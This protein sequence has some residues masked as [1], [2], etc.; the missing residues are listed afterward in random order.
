MHI[1]HL[2]V[3]SKWFKKNA[4]CKHTFNSV[5]NYLMVLTQFVKNINS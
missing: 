5:L 1:K 2:T 4:P 3:L